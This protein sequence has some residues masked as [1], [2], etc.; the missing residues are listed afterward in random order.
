M[1]VVVVL[2][3]IVVMVAIVVMVVMVAMVMMMT[4]VVMVVTVV[5]VMVMVVMVMMLLVRIVP[6]S[7]IP[8]KRMELPGEQNTSPKQQGSVCTAAK[9]LGSCWSKTC[10]HVILIARP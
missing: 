10:L 4:V 3:V 6:W 8:P 1:V 5:M 9:R 2:W 7:W